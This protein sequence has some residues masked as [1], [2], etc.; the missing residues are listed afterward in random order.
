MVF[1]VNVRWN[2]YEPLLMNN[3]V[4]TSNAFKDDILREQI[5]FVMEQVPTMQAGSFIVALVLCY[6]VRGIVAPASILVWVLMVF[7]IV[8][9]RVV[10][11]YR[12]GKVREEP[13]GGK[14]WKNLYLILTLISGII[15][16][17]S[18][19]I[20][21]PAGNLGLATL[22]VLVMASLSAATTFIYL[23]SFAFHSSTTGPSL[24]PS[25]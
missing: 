13:F 6:V 20:I 23:R 21:F 16:G 7:L 11:Y 2:P 4:K 19:F 3:E 25:L 18:A 10:L 17:A 9:S 24:P 12:F 1:A 14:Y 22:F 5:R 15:W 8:F